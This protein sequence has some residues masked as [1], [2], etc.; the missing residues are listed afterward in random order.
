M[1]NAF[2][3]N[4]HRQAPGPAH[5]AS[6]Y[7]RPTLCLWGENTLGWRERVRS[8]WGENL[9]D[10]LEEGH[11]HVKMQYTHGCSVHEYSFRL[12]AEPPI[13][14][15]ADD[16]VQTSPSKLW[17]WLESRVPPHGGTAH[18]FD[19]FVVICF[20]IQWCGELSYYFFFIFYFY[21]CPFFPGAA[22]WLWKR[23]ICGVCGPADPCDPVLQ[24]G[25]HNPAVKGDNNPTVLFLKKEIN[26]WVGLWIFVHSDLIQ[27]VSFIR[28]MKTW[29]SRRRE[30]LSRK[31]CF[32]SARTSLKVLKKTV[33]L[34]ICACCQGLRLKQLIYLFCRL[35]PGARWHRVCS[36]RLGVWWC[37]WGVHTDEHWHNHQWKGELFSC[38][39]RV[40]YAGSNDSIGKWCWTTVSVI[41]FQFTF[42]KSRSL[43]SFYF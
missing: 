29:R 15:L 2:C 31:A 24:T 35:Q 23:C 41:L 5:S 39:W 14:Q 18:L 16:E 19:C 12:L 43:L 40:S 21:F 28:W 7:T 33:Y 3:V 17:Y 6:F 36:K 13:N 10:F 1:N 4:R 27:E 37:Q 38:T 34:W 20:Q 30:T 8:L 22:H 11:L 9:N 42:F 32:T 25:L 26:Q